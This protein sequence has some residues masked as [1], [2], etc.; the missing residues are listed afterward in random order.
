MYTTEYLVK[1][2]KLS[3]LWTY[4]S[5]QEKVFLI[6]QMKSLLGGYSQFGNGKRQVKHTPQNFI[7]VIR[8]RSTY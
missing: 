8:S 4:L 3:P 2:F 7:L 6:L 5:N 1:T